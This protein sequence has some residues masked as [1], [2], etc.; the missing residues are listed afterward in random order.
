MNK[1]LLFFK[2]LQLFN[3]RFLRKSCIF[4]TFY[5]RQI[6]QSCKIGLYKKMEAEFGKIAFYKSLGVRE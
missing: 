1:H 4:W 2:D 6:R 5:V 3:H